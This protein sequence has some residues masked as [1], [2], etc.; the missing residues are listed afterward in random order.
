MTV[1]RY[2]KKIHLGASV[3]VTDLLHSGGRMESVIHDLNFIQ[4][5]YTERRGRMFSF[6]VYWRFG[7]FKN[8]ET[9]EVSAYDM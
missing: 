9:V 5:N 1:A 3:S 6:K 4:R 8:A 2:F 7:R